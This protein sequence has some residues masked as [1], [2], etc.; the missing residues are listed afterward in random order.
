LNR[1]AVGTT[2]STPVASTFGRDIWLAGNGSG[3]NVPL[4]PITWSGNIG[5]AGQFIKSGDGE[6]ELMGTNTYS[7]GTLGERGTL[8][9]ASDD[10]LGAPGRSITLENN[11]GLRAPPRPSPARAFG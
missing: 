9:V 2:G 3:I 10:K 4:Y 7:G 5:G 8:R 11:G 6:L 1:G